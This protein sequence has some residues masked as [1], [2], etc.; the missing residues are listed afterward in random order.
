MSGP[1]LRTGLPDLSLNVIADWSWFFK[2]TVGGTTYRYTDL[3]RPAGSGAFTGSV[4]GGSHTWTERGLVVP[5]VSQNA[6]GAF[7]AQYIELDNITHDIGDL[8]NSPGL[9]GCVF[10]LWIGYFASDLVTLTG[11]P[12][13]FLS[14]TI[15][16]STH[17]IK[18]QLTLKPTSTTW[19]R[20]VL[21]PPVG[22]A[23]MYIFKDPATCQYVGS[24]TAC[25]KTRI[26]CAARTGGSNVSHFGGIDLNPAPGT[27]VNW[28]Y[29][30][31]IVGSASP[32]SNGGNGPAPPTSKVQPPPVSISNPYTRHR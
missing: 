9:R 8:A 17:K 30:Y 15:D 32:S 7:T 13:K 6:Q 19:A 29:Q 12:F 20:L 25:K 26:D 5:K 2:M 21:G 10:E 1:S 22:P 23:C 16:D 4:D 18:S 28:Q 3:A 24:D 14:G 11:T 27:Y 31:I